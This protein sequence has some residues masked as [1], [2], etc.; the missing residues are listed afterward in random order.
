MAEARRWGEPTGA[1]WALGA[2]LLTITLASGARSSFAAFLLPIEAELGLD[3]AVTAAAGTLSQLAYAVSLPLVGRLALCVGA[4][5]V[6]LASVV[7]L[8]LGGFGVSAATQAWQVLLFAGL[9][10]GVGFGGSTVVPATALLA[11]WFGRRLGLAAGVMSSALPAGQSLFVPLAVALIPLWGWRNTYILLGLL[12]AAVAIPALGWLAS[13]PPRPSDSG[14]AAAPRPR[15]GLDVWLLALGYFGCGFTDQFVTL[16]LV[17]LLVEAEVEPLAAGGLFSLL[18][19]LGILGSV[20]SGPL[21]D[22]LSA[23]AMLCSLYLTRALTLPLLLLAGSAERL[24]LLAVFAVLF[25]LTYISNQA[26]GTR[27]V[28]D[29]YGAQAVGPLMGNAGFAHQVG[30]ATGIALGGL[31]VHLAGG[32]GPAV[33]VSAGVA[34]AAALLQLLIPSS[35]DR[36]E[37]TR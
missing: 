31:S 8:A 17:T 36:S 21:A 9:L 1:W 3:R 25:G 29:R 16:H 11:G 4:R 27:L 7:V 12:L 24:P 14:H 20:L 28:R 30:G 13:D 34:L 10:P 32:Y 18:M 33:V 22:R 5:R 23:R 2:C 19:A 35:T 15:A 26:P 6:M 37:L